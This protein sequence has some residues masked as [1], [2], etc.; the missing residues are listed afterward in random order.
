[1]PEAAHDEPAATTSLAA[2]P[3]ETPAEAPAVERAS[4]VEREQPRTGEPVEV[5]I[6]SIELRVAP[7]SPPA[8]PEQPA[9]LEPRPEPQ[10]FDA[11]LAVR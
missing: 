10:G 1:V 9:G 3:A 5:H 2:K 7:P 6:G 4:V 11:Y 8:Q